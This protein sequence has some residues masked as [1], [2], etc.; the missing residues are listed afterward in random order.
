MNS[1]KA[2]VKQSQ[3]LYGKSRVTRNLRHQWVEKT[4]ELKERGIHITQTGKF[5]GKIHA[6]AVA[7]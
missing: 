7:I 6:D 5:P 3:I 2:L 4:R 1:I